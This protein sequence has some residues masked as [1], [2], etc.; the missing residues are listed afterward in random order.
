MNGDAAAPLEPSAFN[1]AT[2]RFDAFE[3]GQGSR[4]KKKLKETRDQKF[5]RITAAK[6]RDV[7]TI[8]S[9]ASSRRS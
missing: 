8:R 4:D 7:S 6:A 2:G 1:E 9:K 3:A 5:L